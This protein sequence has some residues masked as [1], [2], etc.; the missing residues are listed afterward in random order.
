MSDLV[1]FIE[2]RLADDEQLALACQ[3]EVG[4]TRAGEMYP[5]GSG[6]ADRDDFP[7][8]PWG[9]R[10]AELA[11]IAAY[12]PDRALRGVESKRRIL[13]GVRRWLDP[14]PGRPCTNEDNPW[15]ECELH[16]AA[17]G[18]IHADVLPLLALEWDTHPDYDERWRP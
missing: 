5:D 7:S 9:S 8:Y 1:A 12:G 18:R 10:P 6:F 15:V 16:V 2:A 13:A 11:Y 4:A 3:A 17:T 14:H